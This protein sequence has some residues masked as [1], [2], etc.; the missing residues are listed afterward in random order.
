MTTSQGSGGWDFQGQNGS[1]LVLGHILLTCR[2]L[3][4]SS[5]C[6]AFTREAMYEKISFLLWAFLL[7]MRCPYYFLPWWKG[8]MEGFCSLVLP[9]QDLS[10]TKALHSSPSTQEITFQWRRFQREK[11]FWLQ[12]W[13]D[14]V[15]AFTPAW[16][17]YLI[18][19]SQF[20]SLFAALLILYY[21]NLSGRHYVYGRYCEFDYPSIIII[22]IKKEMAEKCK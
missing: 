19:S 3:L 20:F 21:S 13:V 1:P 9:I 2:H 15:V 5:S 10:P 7:L 18:Q 11:A 6:V 22:M 14:S 4:V 17:L 16:T 12:H 8:R